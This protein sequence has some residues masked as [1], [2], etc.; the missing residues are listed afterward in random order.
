V[1]GRSHGHQWAILMAT[2]GQ[3]SWPPVGSFVAAYG[4]FLVAAVIL[5]LSD[6]QIRSSWAGRSTGRRTIHSR[7]PRLRSRPSG[8]LSAR[9]AIGNQAVVEGD[10]GIGTEADQR[11]HGDR[12]PCRRAAT[13][14]V[15][16]ARRCRSEVDYVAPTVQA[17][18]P[19]PGSVAPT[20]ATEFPA[21]AFLPACLHASAV[22]RRARRLA[23]VDCRHRACQ[24][25]IDRVHFVGAFCRPAQPPRPPNNEE[26][27]ATCF[28][29]ARIEPGWRR[30][31]S[32][33]VVARWTVFCCR[34]RLVGVRRLVFDFGEVGADRLQG[35]SLTLL[36]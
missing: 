23:V 30:R 14:L 34:R 20:R 11:R 9:A 28:L 6:R 31:W 15:G 3:F 33:L 21:R 2:S 29:P 36:R 17:D 27:P 16:Y 24:R 26:R 7:A 4:Q 22:D 12:T 35:R 10:P 5:S 13:C 19:W 1:S 18:R 32:T 8:Y 25:Q